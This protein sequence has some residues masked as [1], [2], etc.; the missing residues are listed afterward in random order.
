MPLWLKVSI[1]ELLSL[2]PP[3]PPSVSGDARVGS[4]AGAGSSS[5]LGALTIPSPPDE[6]HSFASAL[7]LRAIGLP[8]GPEAREQSERALL[9]LRRLLGTAGVP[10]SQI[11]LRSPSRGPTLEQVEIEVE[12]VGPA[13]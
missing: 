11:G 8:P 13:N 12:V 5:G 2:F 1:R 10:G 9:S 3:T 4:E 6:K 7:S